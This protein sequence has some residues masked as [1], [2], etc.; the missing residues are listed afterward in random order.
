MIHILLKGKIIHYEPINKFYT[1]KYQD[2]DGDEYNNNRIKLYTKKK[3]QYCHDTSSFLV[4]TKAD[5]NIFFIPTK[6]SPNPMK[7]EYDLQKK[8]TRLL[9]GKL[10]AL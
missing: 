3:Q 6:A 5:H 8:T 1:I 7:C 4:T 9:K 2:G 10:A